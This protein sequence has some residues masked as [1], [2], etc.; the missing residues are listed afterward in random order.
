MRGKMR[1]K[2]PWRSRFGG[3]ET[4]RGDLRVTRPFGDEVKRRQ[5]WGV[6]EMSG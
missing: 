4:C 6:K 2:R 1:E 3:A 5:K